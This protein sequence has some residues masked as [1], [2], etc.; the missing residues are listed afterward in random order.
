MGVMLTPALL[1]AV[2]A[3]TA[4]LPALEYSGTLRLI[5]FGMMPAMMVWKIRYGRAAGGGP[6]NAPPWVAGGK[7]MLAFVITVAAAIISLE[8]G[9]KALRALAGA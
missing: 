9:G 6:M 3:P 7:A 2:C 5:L 1:V 8:L 4:F